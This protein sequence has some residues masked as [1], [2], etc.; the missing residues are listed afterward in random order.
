MYMKL[1]H[2]IADGRAGV[3]TLGALLDLEPD[4]PLLPALA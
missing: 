3:P 1:H 4:P 2:T